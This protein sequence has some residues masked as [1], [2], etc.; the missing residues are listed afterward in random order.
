VNVHRVFYSF[1][2]RQSTDPAIIDDRLETQTDP[3]ENLTTSHVP[4]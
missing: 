1:C 4:I 3:P 2:L